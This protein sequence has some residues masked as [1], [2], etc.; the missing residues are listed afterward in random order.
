MFQQIQIV[1]LDPAITFP[2]SISVKKVVFP[3]VLGF[4]WRYSF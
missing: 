4:M 3:E 1:S 2:K